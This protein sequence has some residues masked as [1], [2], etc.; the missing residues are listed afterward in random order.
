MQRFKN[1]LVVVDE[2]TENRA[3]VERAVTL[4][5][6]NQAGLRVVNTVR[7]LSHQTPRP[8]TREPP[9]DAHELALDI[10]E[11]WPAD[12]GLPATAEPPVTVK[13]FFGERLEGVEVPDTKPAVVIREHIVEEESQRLNQWVDYIRRSG[14]PVTGK[15]LCGT[16]FLEIIREVLRHEHDLVMTATEGRGGL[17]E[18]LFGSTAM[19]LMRSCPCPVW[20][21]KPIHPERH[22]RILA[23]VDPTRIDQ[24]QYTVSIKIM[25]LATALARR[26]QCELVV[27]HCW[28][29]PAEQSLRRGYLIASSELDTWVR[30]ARGLQRRRLTELLAPYNLQDLQSQVYMLKGEPGHLIPKL[31][32]RM[33]IGLTVM[34]TVRRT[35]VAGLLIGN[36]AERILRQVD[37]SVLTVKP[38]GFVTPVRLVE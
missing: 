20:V 27:V 19:H 34:G 29:F 35:G 22:T 13:D 31:A 15:M 11:E 32:V 2:K 8:I 1:I 37:C 5:Q 9:T 6:R 23:A 3:V 26:D 36:T 33:E 25:D 30:R 12:A 24:E 21:V 14:V 38:E 18:R 16:P 7:A 28:T 4:A 10:I 17:R